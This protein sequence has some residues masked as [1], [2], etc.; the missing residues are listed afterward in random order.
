MVEKEMQTV[1]IDM[2]SPYLEKFDI[3][4][5]THIHKNCLKAL[6]IW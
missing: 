4:S 3:L 2:N 5:A 6:N 1:S